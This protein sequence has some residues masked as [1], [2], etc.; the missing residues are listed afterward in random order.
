VL[1]PFGDKSPQ[2]ASTAFV[3]RSAHVIG[4]VVIGAHSSV[5]FGAVIR[6][7]VHW[8]RVG[9]RTNVQDGAVIHVTTG[10]WPTQVGD[11]VTIGHR[12]VLHGCRVG[13]RC[14]I[15][16]GAIVLDG[17]EVGD[18]CLIGAGALV[19]P[20]TAIPSGSLV[21]GSPAKVIRPLTEAER[22]QLVESAEHYVRHAERY[23]QL[24][25]T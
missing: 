24:G 13:N 23:R 21:L 11:Q 3:H 14:L 5:W 12:A 8:I 16:I 19:P 2:L 10:R 15:G 22:N 9:E 1:I 6:G 7:D 18:D 17:V 20:R 25:I 4:D